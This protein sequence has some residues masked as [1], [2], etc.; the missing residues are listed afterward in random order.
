[1]TIKTM[2]L[3]TNA[4]AYAT[5]KDPDIEAGLKKLVNVLGDDLTEAGFEES[6]DTEEAGEALE[7]VL[8]AHD[9][10]DERL[11]AAVADAAEDVNDDATDDD[12]K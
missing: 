5:F 3:I 12:A 6:S 7:D 8:N 10:A 1:M 9:D 2:E 4:L 11:T